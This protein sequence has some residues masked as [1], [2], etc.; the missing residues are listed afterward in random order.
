VLPASAQTAPVKQQPISAM[1]DALSKIPEWISSNLT[2][3]YKSAA[4]IAVFVMVW[5]IL[6][7]TITA[8]FR[9][10]EGRKFFQ[11]TTPSS[12]PFGACFSICCCGPSAT[13]NLLA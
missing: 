4:A 1:I 3:I 2:L 8:I 6:R 13:T 11:A 7:T 10:L 12:P 9:R 5:L